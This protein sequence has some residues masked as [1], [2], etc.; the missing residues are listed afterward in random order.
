MPH[1]IEW[2]LATPKISA[3]LAVEQAHP[4]HLSTHRPTRRSRRAY[5]RA[6]PDRRR[7]DDRPACGPDRG[8]RAPARPRRR[9]RR[10][11]RADRRAPARRSPDL[12]A[13]GRPVPDRDEHLAISRQ[14]LSRW[15]GRTRRRRSRPSGS[16]PRCRRRPPGPP[17]PYPDAPLYVLGLGRRRRGVRRPAAPE[18]RARRGAGRGASRPRSSSAT[19]PRRRPSTTSTARSGSIRGGAVLVGMHRNPWWLTPDGPTLDSGAYVVGPR[20]RDRRRGRGSSASRRRRSSREAVADLRREVAARRRPR[21]DRARHRDGRRRRPHRRPGEPAGRPARHLRPE[22]QARTSPTSRRA[23]RERGGRRPD[24]IAAVAGRGRRRARLTAPPGSRPRPRRARGPIPDTRDH[25]HDDRRASRGSRSRTRRS[26]PTTR[27]STRASRRPSARVRAGL[28]GALPQPT[29]TAPGATA[30]ATFEVR[31]P[32]DRDLVLGTFAKGT[33]SD[34]DDAVAAARAAQPAWAATPVARAARDHPPRR[35]AHQRPPDGRRRDHGFEV[36]KNRIEALG[37]VE[38]SADLLRYYAQTMEDNDGYD[39]RDGQ[40]RRLGGPHP[41]D[42]PAARRVRGRQPVQLPDGALRRPDRRRAHRRQHGR[43]QAVERRRRWSAVKLMEA[44]LDAGV[45]TGAINLVMGPGETVG[46]ALQDHPGIDGIVFTGSYEVGMRLFHSFSRDWPRPTHRRD[47]RQEP[48]DRHA[49]RRPRR[50]GRGDHALG[51]RVRRA[52]VLGE[53]ARLRRA[54]GPR[55]ARPAA[56][57]EDRDRSSS[58]TRSCGRTGSGPIIDQRA[59]D[60]HQAAVAEARR[61][62]TVFTGG[63]QL[64]RRRPGARLLRRADRRRRP[65]GDAPA[66]PRRAVRAVHRGPRRSTRSTRRSRLANDSV[67]GLTA[68]VYSEDPAEVADV[69][70]PRSRRACCT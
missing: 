55:R 49:Q 11:R 17:R 53:L 18:P 26:A 12:E 46:Q 42:P 7:P 62:G 25:P 13:T 4:L 29:S 24:A 23:A 41:L 68:G 54:A 37:E 39:R 58:A 65:A 5:H 34:V 51:V 38:E 57:R 36:G 43:V 69:P 64:S 8:P 1:A 52:E 16:S 60:R 15:A 3:V 56:R 19:R 70:R 63:E 44:Y 2:S 20:V 59:V 40:P 14:T 35:R 66:L 31:S 61:D 28:G 32:I 47:G 67:Y 50:G 10:G 6:M 9:H 22:R 48:G 33:A 27:S 45:P 21:L 30:T